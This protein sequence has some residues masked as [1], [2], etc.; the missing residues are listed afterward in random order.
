MSEDSESRTLKVFAAK[1]PAIG[2]IQMNTIRFYFNQIF[3]TLYLPYLTWTY[4]RSL[5]KMVAIMKKHGGVVP[6]PHETVI[7]T[8]ER[9]A[10]GDGTFRET[11]A[12]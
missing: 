12:K 8:W 3:N 11:A 5:R 4:K 10:Q 6:N 7:E 1:N 2:E 9:T